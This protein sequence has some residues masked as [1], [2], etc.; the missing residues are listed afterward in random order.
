MHSPEKP[1]HAIYTPGEITHFGTPDGEHYY[2]H[3]QL[4]DK[5]HTLGIE[6]PIT[7]VSLPPNQ[8]ESV[9]AQPNFFTLIADE[10]RDKLMSQQQQG[11]VVTASR[12]NINF[13]APAL[14][15]AFGPKLNVPIIVVGSNSSNLQHDNNWQNVTP[16]IMLLRALGLTQTEFVG[17]GIL[18]R[19]RLVS[20][21]SKSLEPVARNSN[22][23]S[24]YSRIYD[25]IPFS[26][27]NHEYAQVTETF[28]LT[29]HA[30]RYNPNL[31]TFNDN[32]YYPFFA[33]GVVGL[34]VIPGLEPTSVESVAD[35]ARAIIFYTSG[36]SG[37]PYEGKYSLLHVAEK[38]V[39][40]NKA[41]FVIPKIRGYSSTQN[42]PGVTLLKDTGVIYATD[43]D[44]A[45]ATIKAQWAISQVDHGIYIKRIREDQTYDAL[46]FIMNNPYVGE[47]GVEQ[48]FNNPLIQAY[49]SNIVK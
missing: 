24:F 15:F 7:N 47:M 23:P 28:D 39:S 42:T 49:L 41:V 2:S 14:A 48:P 45:T 46:K 43:M 31:P 12:D 26:G 30:P 36:A 40:Q 10:I 27:K 33:N 5:L 4:I 13:L 44:A 11:F 22:Q 6:T 16:E 35:V 18:F 29:L 9:V 25:Y 20:A 8:N 37:L 19:D 17:V 1:I 34:D 38:L 3:V 21:T 32:D